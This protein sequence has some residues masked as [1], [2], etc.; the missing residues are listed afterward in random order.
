M[1]PTRRS[2]GISPIKTKVEGWIF[3]RENIS[4]KIAAQIKTVFGGEGE[5]DLCIEVVEEITRDFIVFRIAFVCLVD[6]FCN[7]LLY[8]SRCV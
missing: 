7:C 2:G 4:S 3:E 5:I 6:L 8:T 1:V